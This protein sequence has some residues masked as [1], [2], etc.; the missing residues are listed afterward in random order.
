[1]IRSLSGWTPLKRWCWTR[2]SSAFCLLPTAYCF[3][4]VRGGFEGFLQG[5]SVGF[6]VVASPAFPQGPGAHA[7]IDQRRASV[8]DDELDILARPQSHSGAIQL[9]RGDGGGTVFL[10]VAGGFGKA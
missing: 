8:G 6:H 1:M 4:E 5:F 7:I 3:S 9:P 2:S 10:I